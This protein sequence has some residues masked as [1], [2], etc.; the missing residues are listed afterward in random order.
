MQNSYT[1]YIP[2]DISDIMDLLGW[3]MLYSPKFEDDTGFFPGRSIATTFFA[4]NEGLKNIRKRVGDENY[5]ALLALSD[6]MRAH[7]EAD[8]ESKTGEVVNGSKC[9]LA[10]EEII[11]ASGRRRPSAL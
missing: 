11:K 7:F 2:Q 8:P 4:L 5:R 10:M 9:I 3:M 1:P 6:R